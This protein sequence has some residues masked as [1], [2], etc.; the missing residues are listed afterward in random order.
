M[1]QKERH[2]AECTRRLAII[3]GVSSS[4]PQF[5]QRMD[6]RLLSVGRFFEC[7]TARFRCAE[8]RFSAM[9]EMYSRLSDDLDTPWPEAGPAWSRIEFT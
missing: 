3:N 4:I 5:N 6:T 7:I 8:D 2:K 9:C 1:T